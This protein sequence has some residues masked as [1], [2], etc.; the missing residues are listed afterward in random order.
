[1]KINLRKFAFEPEQQ[2]AAVLE[3]T[4]AAVEQMVGP[5]RNRLL[6]AVFIQP[7]RT[8]SGLILPDKTLDE[9]KY[10]GKAGL[11]LKL[12]PMAFN[13]D[14]EVQARSPEVGDWVFFRAADAWNCGLSI[15]NGEGVECRVVFDDCVVG[16]VEDPE[17][18]W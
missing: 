8:K 6:V 12:G 10:Q 3:A 11:V 14:D 16:V 17:L 13:F 9:A 2:R 18:I 4:A 15:G 7:E 5:F 1:M